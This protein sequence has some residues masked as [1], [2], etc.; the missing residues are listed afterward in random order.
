MTN[1]TIPMAAPAIAPPESECF[2]GEPGRDCPGEI[3]YG[4]IPAATI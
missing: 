1:A 2:L 4:A 3:E